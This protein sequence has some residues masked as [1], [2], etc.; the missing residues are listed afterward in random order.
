MSRFCAALT[1]MQPIGAIDIAAAAS[2]PGVIAV[3]TAATLAAV[4]KPWQTRLAALPSHVSPPQFPL[5]RDEVTW[6]GEPVVAVVANSRAEA[7]DAIERIAIEWQELPAIGSPEA[8]ASPQAD[9]VNSA[10]RRQSR[11]RA[12]LLRRRSRSGLCRSRTSWSSTISPS[13]VKPA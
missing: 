8:S 12:H 5:A 3:V 6:Q 1:L 7:E 4:C 11:S 13:A 2:S 9:K 10:A